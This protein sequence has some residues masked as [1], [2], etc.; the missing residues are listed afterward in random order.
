MAVSVTPTPD[1]A[2][3]GPPTRLFRAD[4]QF[5]GTID[6]VFNV[7]SDGR[8]LLEVAPATRAASSIVVL[9]NWATSLRD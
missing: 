2:R 1:G 8:F 6:R 7:S 9:Q 4:V 5:D 3:F